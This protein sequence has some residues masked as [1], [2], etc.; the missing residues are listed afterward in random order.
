MDSSV[1]LE[2]QIWF[3]RVCHH[4]PFSLYHRVYKMFFFFFYFTLLEGVCNPNSLR[5][6][7][8]VFP[9]PMEPEGSLA[10]LEE[11][12]WAKSIQ[13]TSSEPISWSSILIFNSSIRPPPCGLFPLG[14]ST[15][16]VYALRLF[17]RHTPF[18]SP[19]L[20]WSS[21]YTVDLSV[22]VVLLWAPSLYAVCNVHSISQVSSKE[23]HSGFDCASLMPLWRSLLVLGRFLVR[24]TPGTITK[25][26]AAVQV[27]GYC[28]RVDFECADVVLVLLR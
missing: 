13:S 17:V 19:F 14:F 9:H 8:P 26:C 7:A 2:D 15:K 27:T 5:L 10:R 25:F 28:N 20:I 22:T 6:G 21:G 11:S 16:I 3:L 18:L 24:F 23:L 4:I 1:L 12:A